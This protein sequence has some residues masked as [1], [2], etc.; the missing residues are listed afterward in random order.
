MK[1]KI[2]VFSILSITLFFSGCSWMELFILKNTSNSD[3]VVTYEL[4]SLFEDYAIFRSQPTAF[5]LDDSEN[6]DWDQDL[7]IID[8]DTSKYRIQVVLP[9]HSA[10][11]I[12]ALHNSK[13]VSSKENESDFNLLIMTIQS[14]TNSLEILQEEF[15]YY[16]KKKDNGNIEYLIHQQQPND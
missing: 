3:V 10:L 9:S 2:I 12:G 8:V 5:K 7:S 14:N 1:N 13:Y 16:F 11:D 15:D 4:D 6:I